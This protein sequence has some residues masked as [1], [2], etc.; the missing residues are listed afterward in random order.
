MSLMRIIKKIIKIFV[1]ITIL[2]VL[3]IG[4]AV[5]AIWIDHNAETRLPTPTGKFAVGRTEYVWTDTTRKD[6]MV[7]QPST[8]RELIAWIWYPAATSKKNEKFAAYLPP[9]WQRAFERKSGWLMAHLLTRDL[10]RVQTHSIQNAD[11]SPELPSYPIVLMRAGLSALTLNYTAL[12]EDLADHGYVVVGLDAPYRT[13]VVVLPNGQVITRAPQ[14]NAELLSGDEQTQLAD[15]LVKAWSEDMRFAIDELERL[16]TD[17]PA[18]RFNGRLNMKSIGV[19]GHSLGGA[20]ALQFCYDDPQCKAGID[21]DGAPLG[22]VIRNGV[23]QPFMFLLGA[24]QGEPQ[25]EVQ[26]VMSHM[27]SIYYRIPPDR[28]AFLMIRGAS[29]F[30]FSDNAVLK[31]PLLMNLLHILGIVHLNGRRQLKIT[32]YCLHTFF[33][34]Y[35]KESDTSAIKIRTPLYPELERIK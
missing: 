13:F 10:S 8:K 15:K 1:A 26:N 23:T 9:P 30:M 2:A 29:H 4:I 28:R 11:L 5:F 27:R 24:H 32:A 3:L 14:N 34:K 22:S 20:T 31:S 12:A 19:F 18:G 33:D 25:A 7:P 6:M 21:I 35:L 16:N 17:D